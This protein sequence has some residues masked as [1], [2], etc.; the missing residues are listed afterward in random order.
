MIETSDQ[1]ATRDEL[2]GEA[3][4]GTWDEIRARAESL[5]GMRLRLEVL[6]PA[7]PARSV[8]ERKLSGFGRF[9]GILSSDDILRNRREDLELEEHRR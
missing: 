3:W 7:E 9:A 2:I 6:G 1:L 8:G 4:E 5:S